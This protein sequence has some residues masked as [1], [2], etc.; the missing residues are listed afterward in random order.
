LKPQ[1]LYHCGAS[2]EYSVYYKS[3]TRE[4]FAILRALQQGA[5]VEK[6]CAFLEN[7]RPPAGRIGHPNCSIGSRNGALSVVLLAMKNFV[8][9]L[10]A[11]RLL[12]LTSHAFAADVPDSVNI[13]KAAS[14][15]QHFFQW[16]VSDETFARPNRNAVSSSSIAPPNG[17]TGATSWTRQPY[18]TRY[19]AHPQQP[20]VAIRVDIDARPDLANATARGAGP[21][22]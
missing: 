15:T 14:A 7:R 18:W 3:L 4:Q 17:V 6:A 13:A 1:R 5:S 9:V 16:R 2:D 22:P 12:H 20:L 10:V 11:T 19:R 21:P 8:R